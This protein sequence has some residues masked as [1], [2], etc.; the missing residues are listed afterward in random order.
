MY[1][2]HMFISVA[3][4][5]GFREQLAARNTEVESEPEAKPWGT[6]E[7]VVRDPNGLR[8]RFTEFAK[9]RES[10]S[11][12]LKVKI[13]RRQLQYDELKR[14]YLSVNW[15]RFL[16]DASDVR[17]SLVTSV[18][19]YEGDVVGAASISGNG[20]DAFVI[21]DVMVHPRFQGQGIGTHLMEDLREWIS[22]KV[23]KGAQVLLLTGTHTTTF[24]ERLGFFGPD[25]GLVGMYLRP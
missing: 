24:Y 6:V 23:P 4:V 8:L 9:P 13:E 18:A 11:E 12:R 19:T 16:L 17:P 3:N 14:L 22:I 21:R 1:D 20:V 2:A 5:V 7:F 15:G 25:N 10:R